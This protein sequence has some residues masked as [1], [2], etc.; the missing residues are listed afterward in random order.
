MS[1]PTAQ[2]IITGINIYII[3]GIIYS[4]YFLTFKA[5]K[6]DP[7]FNRA[8]WSVKILM[9]PASVLLWPLIAVFGGS[10]DV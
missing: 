7:V 6:V 5:P 8:K 2:L 4:V 3:I 10:K 1:E 9:I